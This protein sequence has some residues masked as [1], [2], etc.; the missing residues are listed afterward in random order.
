MLDAWLLDMQLGA[1][2]EA[3]AAMLLPSG[4]NASTAP[5]APPLVSGSGV[6]RFAVAAADAGAAAAAGYLP[7]R[8]LAS[9]RQLPARAW[10][11]PPDDERRRAMLGAAWPH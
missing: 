5:A 11:L 10:V 4:G 1:D 9:R 3:E 8:A 6:L 7:P 2:R